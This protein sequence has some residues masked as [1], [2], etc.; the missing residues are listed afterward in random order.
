MVKGAQNRYKSNLCSVGGKGWRL[1]RPRSIRLCH[2][3]DAFAVN[4]LASGRSI[5]HGQDMVK[6]PQKYSPRASILID[7]SRLIWR[8]WRGQLPTGIDRACLAYVR[9][10]GQGARAVVQRGGFTHVISPRASQA[11]FALLLAPPKDFRR[12]LLA[13]VARSLPALALGAG[14]VPE[15]SLYLNVGH[16]GLDRAGHGRWVR[17]SKVR[18]VYYV[19]D[20]IPIT[21]PQFTRE[22]ET[23]RHVARME[24]VLTHGA[25]I[26]ANSQDSLARLG[27]FAANRGLVM[28][29]TLCAPLGL[30]PLKPATTGVA[31]LDA[32]YFVILGTIE[33]RKNHKLLLRLWPRL[34]ERLGDA[35]P[36]LVIIG[37]RGWSIEDVAGKLD[38]D[39]ALGRHVIELSNCNDEDLPGWLSHARALLFPSHVEG[40]GLPLME[41]LALGTPAVASDL[42]VY[43]EFAGDIPDYLDP[44]D[45]EAWLSLIMDYSRA[46]SLRA[47]HQRERLAMYKAPSWEEHFRKVD[48]W[49]GL[50]RS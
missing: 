1:F 48:Q 47:A 8:T 27:D 29:R 11:L 49:L 44:D 4:A 34:A 22:G 14:K 46:E 5:V 50:G 45:D 42:A 9:Y 17:R 12:K 21:H 28:Q 3:P 35:T 10:Y 31:P 32:P 30:E 43:R 24:T 13:L 38:H 41:A 39:E 16:T 20:L 25:A 36:K 2:S 15:G 19:H 23:Q 6:T 26:I 40:Q 18:A 33:A 7:V 37:R